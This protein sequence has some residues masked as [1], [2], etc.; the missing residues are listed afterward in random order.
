MLIGLKK[1]WLFRG[2][3]ML[4]LINFVNLSA[5]FYQSSILDSP[6][7]EN[8][9]PIDSL[10]ELVLEYM[11]DMDTET[12]PDTE[13]PHEKNKFSDLKLHFNLTLIDIL[14]NIGKMVSQTHSIYLFHFYFFM[15]EV[16]A[17]PPK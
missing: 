3:V 7:L 8:H 14:R 17:P 6:L 4:L 1:T 10:A 2:M 16:N 15:M 12:I 13:V 11:L 5:N 9:D